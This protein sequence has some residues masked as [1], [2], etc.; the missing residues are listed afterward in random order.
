M[1]DSPTRAFGDFAEP[2]VPQTQSSTRACVGRCLDVQA[3]RRRNRY[4]Q[5][6]EDRQPRLDENYSTTQGRAEIEEAAL[7]LALGHVLGP[8]GDLQPEK[9]I[10]ESILR[11]YVGPFTE[12]E[13]VP[14]TRSGAVDDLYARR[15]GAALVAGAE[16]A[17]PE[18]TGGERGDELAA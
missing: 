7:R 2:R 15:T 16:L 8:G 14:P 9:I 18:G 1:D 10:Q 11:R 17:V 6:F 13:V 3:D 12:C 4:R 5:R